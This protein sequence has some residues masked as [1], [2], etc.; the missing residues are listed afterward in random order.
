MLYCYKGVGS[1]LKPKLKLNIKTNEMKK[2]IF[3]P[4]LILTILITSCSSD[5]DNSSSSIFEGNWSGQYT[6]NDDNG[7]W[8]VNINSDGIVSGTATSTV[9]SESYDINGTTSEN[10]TL[11]AT[12]G[13]TSAGGEFIGQLNGNSGNG[14]WTNT[15][16]N[17]NGN[18]TGS[19]Q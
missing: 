2:L 10:G 16:V 17:Y 3:L 4:I 11:T 19:K 14:T 9:F 15:S 13:T 18:W 12:L 1:K 7:N 8:T 5:D 6:G